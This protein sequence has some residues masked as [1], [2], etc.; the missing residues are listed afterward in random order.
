MKKS[1][2]KTGQLAAFL[3]AIALTSVTLTGCSSAPEEQTNN[4]ITMAEQVTMSDAWIK[5]P[6]MPSMT[7]L[8]GELENTG[9]EEVVLVGG[10]TSVAGMVE[11]HEVVDGQ[12]QEIPGGLVI[13]AGETSELVPGGNHVML[14]DLTTELLVGEDVTVTLTF[15]DGSSLDVIGLV[16]SSAGGE[17]SYNEKDDHDHSHE[18]GK[19]HD[20]SHEDG[21][22]ND[23]EMG[24]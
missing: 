23:Q 19:D 17:E 12:M 21:K 4:D 11:I 3:L 5:E 13:A 22:E 6:T 14:M 8:F 7:A 20:H 2:Q 15:E 16:K 24:M 10:S 1:T 9:S 18:D